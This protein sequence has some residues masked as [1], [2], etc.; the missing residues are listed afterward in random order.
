MPTTLQRNIHLC[1]ICTKMILKEAFKSEM[2]SFTSIIILKWIFFSFVFTC[3]WY[4]GCPCHVCVHVCD[5]NVYG[6]WER[7]VCYMYV[8]VVYCVCMHVGGHRC[9]CYTTLRLGHFFA[10]YHASKASC[11]MTFQG[12]SS[13]HIPSYHRSPGTIDVQHYAQLLHEF[14]G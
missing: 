4:V 14:R 3:V 7:C 8:C 2:T 10:I 13:P 1:E 5:W 6:V 12:S 9:I 11:P